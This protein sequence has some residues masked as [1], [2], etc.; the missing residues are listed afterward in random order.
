MSAGGN[1]ETGTPRLGIVVGLPG[2]PLPRWLEIAREAEAAGFDFIGGG[3]GATENFSVMGALAATTERVELMST[4]AHWSRTPVTFAQGASSLAELSGGRYRLGLGA[5]PRDFSTNWH[6]ISYERPTERLEDLIAAIRA[7][8]ATSLGF[9]GGHEGPF[10]RFE[11]YEHQ[12]GDWAEIPIYLGV[13]RPRAIALAG[14]VADGVIF[15]LMHSLEWLR[16]DGLPALE[17]GRAE[18]GRDPAELDIGA[19]TIG[20]VDES[21]ERAF[22]LARSGLAFYFSVPYLAPLLELHGFEEEMERGVQAWTERDPAGMVDAVSDRMVEAFALAGTPDDIRNKLSAYAK[23]VHFLE[24]MAPLG[25]SA[26]QTLEQTRR[27]IAT[28]SKVRP[29]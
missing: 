21:R 12:L 7:A 20:A 23:L 1:E 28:L 11:R 3:E 19:L 22:D 6:D 17:G 14:R 25:L 15:N 9:P 8:L 4:I 16:A 29:A 26:E 5:S 2:V 27:L 18:A 24:V 10:Y 13:T